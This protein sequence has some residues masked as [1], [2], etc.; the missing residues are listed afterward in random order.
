MPWHDEIQL[1]P[2]QSLTSEGFLLIK[3]V[4]LARIGTQMYHPM[5][6]PMDGIGD[7]R[8]MIAIERTAD[9]VF[10]PASTPC[11]SANP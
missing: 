2:K 9:E 3:D 7:G 6:L 8:S 1:G 11:S 4:P 5:E 10:D